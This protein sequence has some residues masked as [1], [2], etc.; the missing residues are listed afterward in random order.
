MQTQTI[1]IKGGFKMLA[2]KKIVWLMSF[3][4]LALSSCGED[5][6]NSRTVYATFFPIY[7]M[8]QKIAGDKYEVHSLTPYGQE[9][10][11]YEP[12][13]KEIA[14]MN[15]CPAIL[16][17]GIGL[18]KWSDSLPE[19]LK[20][21]SHV[22]TEGIKTQEINGV[23]DP[24]V[25]LSVKNAIK[26]LRNIKEVFVSLDAE[27]KAYY[28]ANYAEELKRFEELD[29]KFTEELKN[30]KNKYLVVSHAAFGYLANDYG[31]EQIYIAGLEPDAAPSAKKMEELISDTKK[32]NV[33]T[34][35]Y[36]DAVSPD[37]AQKIAEEANVKTE[38]LYTLE[39]IEEE[40]D[41]KVDY[42]SLMEENLKRI[43]KAGN[44]QK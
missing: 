36:E 12:T 19:D 14:G 28:E 26:E 1:C 11:D 23:T 15:D 41:G 3:L 20:E 10:H 30:I 37:I 35:F 33:S 17:N 13:A 21:K 40:D 39:S 2:Y 38:T 32:Y 24:H 29:S 16:L 5:K 31:L 22:V 4:P 6:G 7:D 8:A 34:I 44:E 43:L 9:P 42:V 18:D 25:W 27:N